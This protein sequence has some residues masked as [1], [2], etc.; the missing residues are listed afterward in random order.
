MKTNP[1][2]SK[3]I[4]DETLALAVE[5]A[6]RR[7]EANNDHQ[8]ELFR[9]KTTHDIATQLGVEEFLTEARQEIERRK[10]QEE[11][12]L[13]AKREKLKIAGIISG[14]VLALLVLIW[15][16]PVT[17]FWYLVFCPIASVFAGSKGLS[18]ERWFFSSV[19]GAVLL[20]FI[21]TPSSW[22]KRK[23]LNESGLMLSILSVGILIL[24]RIIP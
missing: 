5:M 10:N 1:V 7:R 8:N 15:A 23:S 21:P 6:E 9:R 24:T 16:I 17:F 11:I 18:Q 14:S 12:N 19:I 22:I 4:E 20:Q 2:Q 3:D 13:K